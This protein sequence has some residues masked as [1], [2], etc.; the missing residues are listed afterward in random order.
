[1]TDS[2]PL[3]Y[4]QIAQSSVYETQVAGS[5]GWSGYLL[6]APQSVKDGIPVAD[7]LDGY[8]GHY[9]FSVRRPA[10]L[11]TAPETFADRVRA[12]IA[13]ATSNRVALWLP[14]ADPLELGSF[15]AC[16]FGFG[17]G[18]DN[19]YQL[20]SNMNVVLG[21][22]VVFSALEQCTLQIDPKVPGLRIST[23]GT[24]DPL[25]RFR[26]DGKDAGIAITGSNDFIRA[27]VP[28]S[29]SNSGC[30]AFTASMKPQVAFEGRVLGPGL[31]YVVDDRGKGEKIIDYRVFPV[32]RLPAQLDLVGCLD[33]SDLFNVAAADLASGHLRS[34]FAV[35]GSPTLTSDA[36]T[37]QGK[38]VLLTPL[39]TQADDVV[40]SP[41]AGGFCWASPS[42]LDGGIDPRSAYLAPAGM[43]GIG[44]K[45]VNAG[46]PQELLCGLF[47]SERLTF[48]TY[49]ATKPLAENDLLYFLPAQPAYAPVFPFDVA[50]LNQPESGRVRDRL[51]GT[52]RVPWAAFLGGASAV[53]Y[54]AEPEGSAL[55]GNPTASGGGG[56]AETTVLLSAPPRMAIAAGTAHPFP[57]V[58]YGGAASAGVGGET[59]AQLE[60]QI[61]SATRKGLISNAA[62]A[63][64]NARHQARN[65]ASLDGTQRRTTPQGFVVEVDP[66]SS[67]Y[68]NVRMAQSL[69]RRRAAL[70]CGAGIPDYLPFAFDKPTR[71]LEDALQS[72]QLFLVAV[73]D[74]PLSDPS[75]G[76]CFE[77]TVNIADWTLS[78]QVGKGA[79]STS[80]RNVMIF[81]Y[82][83]GSL[84]DRISNPNKWT[85]PER[86]SLLA[87]TPAELSGLAYT[88][89]SQWL[90]DYVAAALERAK[91]SSA[92]VYESFARIVTDPDWKGV[93]VLA[94]DLGADALPPEIAALAA[95]IDLPLFAAHHFGFTATRV[96]VDPSSGTIA[97]SPGDSALFGLIDYEDPRYAANLASGLGPD[98]P[99]P[100]AAAGFDF[101]VLQLQSLFENAK[102]TRFQSR[103]QLTV[104]ELFGASV[105]NL[106]TGGVPQP[107]NGVVLSGSYV[108]QGG[109]SA[110]VFE[111]VARSV[112]LADSNV[113]PAVAWN[114]VQ[115]NTLGTILQA[116]KRTVAGRFVIWGAF[117]FAPL[118]DRQKQLLDVTSFGSP[119]GTP[120]EKLGVGLAFSNLVV[121]MTF[122][123]TTPTAKS[124]AVDTDNLAWDLPAS[125]SRE[126]SLFRGFGLALKSF[127]N[128]AG[129]Q[130]AADLGFLPV[131]SSLELNEIE[132]PWFGVVYEIT[133]G[134]PGALASA[135][136]F[137]ST[138]LVAWSPTT[139]ASDSAH[140]L[141]LGMSLPGAA[142][143]AK[144]FSIQGVFKVA[145]GSISILRQ[146]V[147]R[148][149]G[150]TGPD[151]DFYC[152]RID[153][154]GVKIFGIVK[155][156]PSAN[157]QFFLFGD[158]DNTGS[159]GWYAAY[160]ADD[161]P[162]PDQQI[163][164]AQVRSEMPPCLPAAGA[165]AKGR[166]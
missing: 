104:N 131:T 127:V 54:R 50:D 34:G 159:L 85:A 128:A 7:S 62:E 135:A 74:A 73:N 145:V 143:G 93:L 3:K 24:S 121:G 72:N 12:Y 15:D 82:C 22:G 152:L 126:A 75:H 4:V 109:Q 157:I 154:I 57:L 114:R 32:D 37:P 151:R 137:S 65:R 129:G 142:P 122:P 115:F 144:L 112:L 27:R 125:V 87:G 119:A 111:Q 164:F 139:A 123:E 80:Y 43:H 16:G 36:F 160:V 53:E 105:T 96:E 141:F 69:N 165:G 132:K 81:K 88:G 20:R 31:R 156:P 45:G 39:G 64:W 58:P 51:T 52:R 150:R 47:G 49:Q 40:P 140:A 17:K 46:Q 68:L 29:G 10:M 113:L 11:D 116:G 118:S 146:P 67:A 21:S 25:L 77:R 148:A 158:P 133:L 102:L 110:Y 38:G 79:T 94:A 6:P 149:P 23:H 95:G 153:D 134:G 117:D 56:S 70:Q 63:A 19:V 130:T 76:A 89:L 9:L 101:T 86:F 13:R 83:D 26:R 124:F 147:P 55:Y 84:K 59:L 60:S 100:A 92:P 14:A 42:P 66:T 106:Y 18:A 138:L 108:D 44:V 35:A 163:A 155:L 103:I 30:F 78:A 48:Q 98:L 2:D 8:L 33:P 97:M 61:L 162:G 5:V 1:M 166:G 136:G 28:A 41:M 71:V 90:Q 161:N 91:G 99:N 120:P 107:A